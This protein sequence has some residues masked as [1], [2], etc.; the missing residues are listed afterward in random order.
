MVNNNVIR[1]WPTNIQ[2]ICAF[3]KCLSILFRQI[4]HFSSAFSA[5]SSAMIAI[6][7]KNLSRFSGIAEE[8]YYLYL[9]Y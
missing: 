4:Q 6:D 2:N 7:I 8:K 1:K 9:K 5:I 3:V